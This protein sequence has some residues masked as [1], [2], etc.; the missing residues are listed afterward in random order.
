MP[1]WADVLCES[2]NITPGTETQ[3]VVRKL[4]RLC[5]DEDSAVRSNAFA[6]VIRLLLAKTVK[7]TEERCVELN[8]VK[9]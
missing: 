5:A 7:F 4:L 8:A 1:L 3:Q 6:A 9:D 2:V